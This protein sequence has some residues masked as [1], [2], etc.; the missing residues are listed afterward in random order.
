M[1]IIM[2]I[3]DFVMLTFVFKCWDHWIRVV[4]TGTYM[5]LYK[6]DT[7][8]GLTVFHVF[9]FS[10]LN[11]NSNVLFEIRFLFII[12]DKHKIRRTPKLLNIDVI[13]ISRHY[14]QF[15]LKH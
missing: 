10:A 15:N 14:S 7:A 12:R 8:M 6:T 5:S 13:S 11:P 9:W 3:S 4:E 2:D 1:S